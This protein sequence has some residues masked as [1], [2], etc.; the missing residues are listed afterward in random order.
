MLQLVH[1]KD[2]LF[3]LVFVLQDLA[4][5]SPTSGSLSVMTPL[6]L[7]APSYNTLHFPVLPHSPHGILIRWRHL[8]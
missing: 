6:P 1:F 5:E 8:P 4:Y 3:E 7:W 2:T